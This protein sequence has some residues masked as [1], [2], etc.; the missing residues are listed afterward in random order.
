MDKRSIL[1]VFRDIARS[2]IETFNGYYDTAICSLRKIDF[3][4]LRD[5]AMFTND[6]QNL[7]YDMTSYDYRIIHMDID[8][9]KFSVTENRSE[10][11]STSIMLLKLSDK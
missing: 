11:S 4:E 7:I 6:V 9:F 2:N 5:E 3:D 10:V 1:D 8:G